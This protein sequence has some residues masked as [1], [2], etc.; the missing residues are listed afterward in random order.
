VQILYK[1]GPGASAVSEEDG[2]YRIGDVPT[3]TAFRLQAVKEGY[4]PVTRVIEPL[5]ADATIEFVLK[6]IPHTLIGIVTE[7]APTT[8]VPIANAS[9][10]VVIGPHAGMRTTTDGNGY[11]SLPGVWDEFDVMVSHAGYE[12]TRAHADARSTVSRLDVALMPDAQP[13]RTSFTGRLCADAHYWFGAPGSAI[14]PGSGCDEIP[15]QTHHFIPVHRTGPLDIK[16]SWE[17]REDYSDEY[18]FLEARCGREAR[19]HKF[20]FF[21]MGARGFGTLRLTADG[22]VVCEIKPSRYRSF[23]GQIARTVYRI[24]VTHPK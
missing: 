9:V 14:Y 18:M 24:D 12:S 7:T 22:P 8:S 6:P 13:T 15:V 16:I 1:G 20:S 5:S 4:E 19:E 17:Y 23:K 11:Y 2:G 21:E 3:S 10:T